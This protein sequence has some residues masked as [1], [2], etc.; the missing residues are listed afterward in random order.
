MLMRSTGQ[1]LQATGTPTGFK[2][3]AGLTAGLAIMCV[4][5]AYVYMRMPRPQKTQKGSTAA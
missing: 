3:Q 4:P 2:V 5:L 1:I